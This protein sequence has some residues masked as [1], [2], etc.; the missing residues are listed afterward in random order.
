MNIKLT[1]HDRLSELVK[2]LMI[3]TPGNY[4]ATLS[5]T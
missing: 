4:R 1:H 3:Y 2:L 5:F